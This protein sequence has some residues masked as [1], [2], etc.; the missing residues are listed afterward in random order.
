MPT[1]L[2]VDDEPTPRAF[3]PKSLAAPGYAIDEATGQPVATLFPGSL[4]LL[5]PFLNITGG[6]AL[7]L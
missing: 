5:T 2:I 3:L 7:I 1:V 6:F 4:R